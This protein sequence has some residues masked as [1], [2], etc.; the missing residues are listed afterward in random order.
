MVLFA[1]MRERIA[2]ADVP[3]PFRGAAIALVTAGLM[4]LAFMG[5]S[6]SGRG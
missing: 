6:R 2:V 5:F 3:V 4:S 1:A